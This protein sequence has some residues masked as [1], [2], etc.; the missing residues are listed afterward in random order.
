M[1]DSIGRCPVGEVETSFTVDFGWNADPCTYELFLGRKLPEK[2]R[3]TPEQ[4]ERYRMESLNAVPG[5]V[6]TLARGEFGKP[7]YRHEILTVVDAFPSEGEI[8]PAVLEERIGWRGYRIT[9]RVKRRP[10]MPT[11]FIERGR[12]LDKAATEGPWRMFSG[13][14]YV[15]GVCLVVAPDDGG[16]STAD[17]EFIA[18]ARSM[19]PAAV[20]ALAR[21]REL[22][23]P[24]SMYFGGSGA[25]CV[26]C[27]GNW[28][29]ATYKATEVES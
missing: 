23:T 8:T 9:E 25:Y 10:A 5:D 12:A 4:K 26:H 20:E 3:T 2:F 1:T 6:V 29:C 27:D 16:V 15:S 18:A 24:T 11:D 13:G 22:H 7:G 19:L 21:V 17:A 14:E 28:P